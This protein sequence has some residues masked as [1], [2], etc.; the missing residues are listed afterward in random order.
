MATEKSLKM[1][2]NTAA[3]P[4]ATML[5]RETIFVRYKTAK[6]VKNGIKNNSTN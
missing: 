1:K 4:K 5:E 2:D 3:K 6:K